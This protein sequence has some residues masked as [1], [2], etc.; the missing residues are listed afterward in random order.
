MADRTLTPLVEGY[1]FL[2]GPRWHDGRLW[3]SDFYTHKVIA[4]TDDGKVEEIT[5]V[6]QQPSG[7]GWLPD[8]TL[9]VVSMRDRRVLRME[10]GELV[11]HADLSAVATGHVNDMVVDAQGG[12]YVGNFGFD[13]MAGD[14]FRATPLVR[15]DP[16]GTT[17]VAT[18][19]LR[20]PNGSIITPDGA[21]LIV[22]ETFGNRVSAFDIAA[23]GSLGPRRDWANFG[24]LPAT[25]DVEELVAAA[26]VG[27]DGNCLDADGAIWIADALHNRV[28]RVAEG[29]EILEEISTGDDGAYACTLGGDDGRTLYVCVAPGFAESE[30]STTRLGRIVATTVDVPRAEGARP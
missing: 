1:T 17:R 24:A 18:E 6:P 15:V 19:D 5:T 27:P 10:D 2:E 4:V 23:D 25:D 26:A 3:L 28:V 9:L 20:F 16:D 14:P 7:L 12:A 13:L 8:G 30:R 22:D 11:E 29:G 21:T